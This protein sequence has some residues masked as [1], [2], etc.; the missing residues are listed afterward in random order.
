MRPSTPKASAASLPPLL[1][2]LLP[3]G[4]N[5]LP[6]GIS[7]PLRTSAFSRRTPIIRLQVQVECKCAAVGIL[8]RIELY[9]RLV[10][11]GAERLSGKY[12]SRLQGNGYLPN[13]I[14]KP[15]ETALALT[16]L[17]Q[18]GTLDL[19]PGVK[20]CAARGGGYLPSYSGRSDECLIAFPKYCRPLKK[21][22]SEY[23][24]QLYYD[25]LLFTPE[26]TRH[27]ISVV[28]ASQVVVGTEYPTQ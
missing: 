25:S 14:G 11:M 19:Y 5:Q 21:Q 15:L 6:G 27:L 9:V 1:L 2:R 22:P 10:A 17:I 13:V 26:D 18:E 12:S 24:K 3:G 7:L 20:I 8:R 4:T 28:G 16:H 23:L